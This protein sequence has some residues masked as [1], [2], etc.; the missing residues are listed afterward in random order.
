MLYV[1]F[2]NTKQQ[3]LYDENIIINKT[4]IEFN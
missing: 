1:R 3:M 2:T 4:T